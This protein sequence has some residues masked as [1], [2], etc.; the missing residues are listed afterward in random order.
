MTE[1]SLEQ[2]KALQ[3]F[4]RGENVFIS[5]PGGSGKSH[6]VRYFVDHL[7]TIGRIH[8]VTSTTGC[9]SILLSNSIRIAGKPIIVKTIHSWSGIR[10]GK[11]SLDELLRLVDKNKKVVREW[12]RVRTLIIDEISMLSKKLFTALEYIARKIR[13]NDR[14]FGGMQIVCLGDFFQLPPVGDIYEPDTFDFAFES[15]AWD[16]VFPIQHHVE[17]VTVFRQKDDAYKRILGEIRTANLSEESKLRLQERVGLVYIPE[18][19]GGGVS[20]KIFPTK[21][22][23][24][25]VNQAQYKRIENTEQ[26]FTMDDYTNVRRYMET[27]EAFDEDV[28]FKCLNMTPYEVEAEIRNLSNNSNTDAEVRLKVGVPVMCL[29]NLDIDMGIANGSMGMVVDFVRTEESENTFISGAGVGK[30]TRMIPLVQFNNGVRKPIGKYTWQSSEFPCICVSQIPLIL[31]YANSIHKMQGASLDVCEMDL[32]RQIFAEHQTYVA[33]SRVK[34]LDGVYLTTFDPSRIRVNP[35]VV[36]FYQKFIKVS[37]E[38]V[39]LDGSGGMVS[40]D[41]IL[42]FSETEC[43]ICINNIENAYTPLNI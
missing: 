6:L 42:E 28:L 7:H 34:S 38:D 10:L 31:C 18:N 33:L 30:E 29:V 14:P 19:H 39:V 43:P 36:Q 27:G 22:Q 13:G 3:L 12:R 21:N 20:M 1:L 23:V 8:Q 9:S 15:P 16:R 40:D 24:N 32:G 11:G 41:I 5:G 25:I 17:L 35:K 2:K 26:V 37:E 4:Q